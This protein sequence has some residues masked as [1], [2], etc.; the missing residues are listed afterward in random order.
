LKKRISST[1]LVYNLA[2]LIALGPHQHGW[3]DQLQVGGSH[4]LLHARQHTPAPAIARL[5][6]SPLIILARWQH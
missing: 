2:E 6:L 3:G 4:L 5:F 1:K